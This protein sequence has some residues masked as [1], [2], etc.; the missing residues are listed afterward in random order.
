[1][2]KTILIENFYNFV[3]NRNLTAR[4]TEDLLNL[5][6]RFDGSKVFI[7][8][9]RNNAIARAIAKTFFLQKGLEVIHEE[10]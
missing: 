8:D 4:T 2:N 10:I 3:L 6:I 9:E 1:M 5:S 7:I